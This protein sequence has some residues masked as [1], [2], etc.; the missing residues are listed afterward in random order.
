MNSTGTAAMLTPA[1]SLFNRRP[2][3]TDYAGARETLAAAQDP[4]GGA[5]GT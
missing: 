1:V 3:V 4:C 2:R 5:D